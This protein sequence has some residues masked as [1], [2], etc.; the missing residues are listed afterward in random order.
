MQYV[1]IALQCLWC[2][3]TC[4]SVQMPKHT[5]RCAQQHY[6]AFHAV[7]VDRV[8]QATH[9]C[10]LSVVSTAQLVFMIAIGSVGLC[11]D[12]WTTGIAPVL[13]CQTFFDCAGTPL[14]HSS[15]TPT[16]VTEVCCTVSVCSSSACSTGARPCRRSQQTAT[17]AIQ[18]W[19]GTANAHAQHSSVGPSFT[20]QKLG[21]NMAAALWQQQQ[22]RQWLNRAASG[23]QRAWS[24]ICWRLLLLYDAFSSTFV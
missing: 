4:C 3:Y 1:Y 13:V 16:D 6:V 5:V 22:Q 20:G 15:R 21:R 17:A 10:T 2:V 23:A 24:T 14:C 12:C 9:G 7:A 11:G 8:S 18:Q 19:T